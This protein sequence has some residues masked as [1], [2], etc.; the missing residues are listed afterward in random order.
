MSKVNGM[1]AVTSP[2][3]IAAK[4]FDLVEGV[5]IDYMHVVCLGARRRLHAGEVANIS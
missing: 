2:L 1:L 3:L 5:V 4:G